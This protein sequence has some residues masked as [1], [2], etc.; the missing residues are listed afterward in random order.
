MSDA[1]QDA[2]SAAI[3]PFEQAIVVVRADGTIAT[4]N[5]GATA[6]YGHTEEEALGRSLE[7]L[8]PTTWPE[9]PE[10]IAGSVDRSGGWAGVIV[11]RDRDGDA[12]LL[13]AT[14]VRAPQEPG[15]AVETSLPLPEHVSAASL[16]PG[17]DERTDRLFVLEPLRDADGEI[18][19]MEVRYVN[20]EAAAAVGRVPEQLVGRR[21]SELLPGYRETL[22]FE[23]HRK[24]IETG[25]PAV[26]ADRRVEMPPGSGIVH[27][28]N[29]MV[30]PYGAG[31]ASRSRDVTAERRA[32]QA[33]DDAQARVRMALAVAP[34][35]VGQL[36]E[37]L[38]YEWLLDNV[39]RLDPADLIGQR[40]GVRAAPQDGERLR[41]AARRVMETGASERLEIRGGEGLEEF[42]ALDVVIAPRADAEGRTR[43]VRI[44]L[45]DVSIH[46]RLEAELRESRDMMRAVLEHT[47][48]AVLVKD[49]DG[50]ILFLN[51]R[52][53]GLLGTT[54]QDAVDRMLVD[55]VTPAEAERLSAH[56]AEVLRTGEEVEVRE[57]L[58][59][60]VL[61]VRRFPI[62][63]ADGQIRALGSIG[64][65]LGRMPRAAADAGVTAPPAP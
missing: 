10:T 3:P 58:G 35:T 40:L 8:L 5:P 6:L 62:R 48:G 28:H 37:D 15:G 4:W 53:A 57:D 32:L 65:D 17:E 2:I 11:R 13:L 50:R 47:P 24:V 9:T 36:N 49:L 42:T 55:L 44:A 16:V 51:E 46:R 43:G 64:I 54:P 12:L 30:V 27:V 19:D 61:L 1:R 22:M 18:A 23:T 56:D 21:V 25:R 7:D 45:V 20:R 34:V 14:R 39:T 52:A 31:I 59:A 29:G 33:L 41:A 63:D 60:S 26:I 38:E